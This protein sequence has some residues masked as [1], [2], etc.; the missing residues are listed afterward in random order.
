MSEQTH[1]G[2]KSANL[3]SLAWN[4]LL[5]KSTVPTDFHAQASCIDLML[6][7]DNSGLIDSLVDFMV[8]SALTK[9]SIETMSEEVN[10][11]ET[12]NNWLEFINEDYRGQGIEVGIR[13]LAK[14]YFKERWKGASFPILKI[15]KWETINNYLLPT[16]AF[17]ID[18]S[19]VYAQD[20]DNNEMLE[21]INYDYY[22]GNI[23]TPANKLAGDKVIITKPFCRWFDKYPVPYLIKRGVYQNWKT[24]DTIKNKQQQLIEQVIPY[25]LLIKKSTEGL[26]H[27]KVKAY[28][29]PELK[30]VVE[31]YK[32]IQSKLDYLTAET[33]KTPIRATNAD[34]ELQHIIP[35]L[36][37]LFKRE[38]FLEGDRAILSGLGFIDVI[39]GVSSSRRESVLNPKPFIS[40]INNGVEDFKVIIKDLLASIKYNN[41]KDHRKYTNIKVEILSSPIKTFMSDEFK[42]VLV[43]SYDRGNLSKETFLELVPEVD[44]RTELYRRKVESKTGVEEDLY[45]HIVRND[46]GKEDISNKTSLEEEE[47]IPEDKKGIN[48]KNYDMANK[49][50]KKNKKD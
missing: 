16:K 27:D 36:D 34:E 42:K 15:A 26:L 45:P 23:F 39:D 14:E 2:I 6:K 3:T 40:E 41:E 1:I 30:Q 46:E 5:T 24:L 33:N 11:K 44:I 12:L 22:L 31:D 19:S 8:S 32:K 49:K 28:T 9:F 25:L 29:E 20:K 10:L 35:K 13:G 38:L 17:F 4:L 7:S 43:Q 37:D 21:L 18:G 50:K 47:D 48:K